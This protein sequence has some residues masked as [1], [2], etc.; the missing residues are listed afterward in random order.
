MKKMIRK[1]I[2]LTACA[3][4]LTA[5]ANGETAPAAGGTSIPVET[6]TTA[7]TT[8]QTTIQTIASETVVST[9]AAVSETTAVTA[10]STAAE[11]SALTTAAAA[12]T[13]NA[14]AKEADCEKITAANQAAQHLYA[15][16]QAA[17][18]DMEAQDP[19]VDD[20]VE[21]SHFLTSE[22]WADITKEVDP[23]YYQIMQYYNDIVKLSRLTFKVEEGKIKYLYVETKDILESF[24]ENDPEHYAVGRPQ[25]G[26]TYEEAKCIRNINAADSFEVYQ[27]CWPANNGAKKLAGSLCSAMCDLDTAGEIKSADEYNGT[28]KFTQQELQNLDAS[29]SKIEALLLRAKEYY[30]ELT[31]WHA[32]AF[33]INNMNFPAAAVVGDTR[34]P[35]DNTGKI[36]DPYGTFPK[37][38]TVEEAMKMQSIDDALKYAPR[39]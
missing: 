24:G 34:Y 1:M 10:L 25:K 7:Q 18:L 32:I 39:D 8:V 21:G 15:A 17:M 13:K 9:T 4:T 30:P 37:A 28:Y 19:P 3:L 27:M 33:T 14:A 23:F 38:A 20:L 35:D 36:Y 5:C 29:H 16:V 31:Q 12:D 6:Q 26:F 11:T 22:D 2:C